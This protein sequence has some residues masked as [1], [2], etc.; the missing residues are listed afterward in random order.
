[1]ISRLHHELDVL[2]GKSRQLARFARHFS[3]TLC[4]THRYLPPLRRLEALQIL[5]G[6]KRI[7][8]IGVAAETQIPGMIGEL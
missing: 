2:E 6:I 3:A 7:P 8:D 5:A 4:K 1:M